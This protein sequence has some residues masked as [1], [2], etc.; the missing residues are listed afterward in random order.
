MSA[1]L[2]LVQS[3]QSEYPKDKG[4]VR[5]YR[6]WDASEK[7][8]VPHR[9]YSTER[10]ALDSA[11]LLIRWSAVSKSIEVYD[12]T[13]ARWLGTYTRRVDSIAFQS[14]NG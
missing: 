1:K 9:C 12:I 13:T 2:Q 10:R 4:T 11:L 8:N 3:K 7:R 14:R 5:P 6:L